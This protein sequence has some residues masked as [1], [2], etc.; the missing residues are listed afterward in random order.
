MT[1]VAQRLAQLGV[2][3]RPRQRHNRSPARS[4]S[5][6]GPRQVAQLWQMMAD[7]RGK[8]Y[9]PPLCQIAWEWGVHE[10]TLYELVRAMRD[11]PMSRQV[12]HRLLC[13]AIDEART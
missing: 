1:Y 7:R 10:T 13:S 8:Y 5:K 6:L 12:L 11:R 9:H 3:R 4:R 2:Q